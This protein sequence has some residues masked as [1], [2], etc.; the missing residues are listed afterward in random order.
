[1]HIVAIG[2]SDAGISAALRAREVD[3]GAEVTVVVADAYPNFSICGIPYYVSGEVTHW[4]NLAHRTIADLEAAGH[5]AAAGHH[6][7]PHRR[8]PAASCS[9]TGPD[10]AEDLLSLR[11]AGH[12][13]RRR[14]GPA[15][16]RRACDALGPGDGVHLLHS[17]GDTFAAHAHPGGDRARQRGHRRR[18]LHR[19]GDGRRADRPRP[20]RSP[21]SSSSPRCCPPSTRELGALVHAELDR[22][23]VTVLTGTAVERDQPRR[24]A[25]RPAGCRSTRSP[26]TA[27]RSPC[28]PTLVLVVV[29]VR[30]DTE[31]RRQRRGRARRP[32]RDR[33]RP[34]DADQPARTSTRPATASITHHRLLGETYLPL[35]TTA[36]KQG[37]V[38]GENALGGSREFAGSLGTQV[39]KIFDQ[40]AARTGLRDHE[41]AAAGFDPVTVGSEADDHKAYYPGSHRIAMRFT[42]DRATG[43]LLGVQL[44]GHKHAEI[45]KRID[46]AATA[47][48]HGMTVDAGQ[49]PRPVL[50]PAARLPLGRRPGRRPG[51]D[52]PG[53]PPDK[54]THHGEDGNDAT[55]APRTRTS[56]PPRAAA[57]LAAAA[58]A[59]GRR[60]HRV[61]VRRHPARR[62]PRPPRAARCG[63]PAP[64]STFDAPFFTVA[65]AAYQ[66][67]HPGVTVSYA[68][69]GS[70]AG[71]TRFTAGTGEL[72]R[73]RRPRQHAPTWPAPAAAPPSRSRSTSAPSSVAY[74]VMTLNGSLKLTGPVL[75]RI[76]LGQ[77]TRWDDPAITALNPGASLPDAY[78]TVVHR[79][80]GSGTTYIFSNYLSHVSPAWATQV[81]TGR[82]L[83]WPVGYGAD[84]NQ[85]VASTIL[86]IPDSIGYA[87]DSYTTGTAINSAAIANR[88]GNYVTPTPA[89]ITADAAAK[90]GHHRGRLLHRQ[91]A[92][93]RPPTRSAATAGSW[94][95]P[96]SPA[97]PPGRPSS[98][99]SAGSPTPGSPTPPTSA[100]SPCPPAVQQ[101]ATATLSRVTG[102][103]G[104]PLTG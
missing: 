86:R 71:I 64:G 88:D 15:A 60:A 45:A 29:G 59:I 35:G 96:A 54:T 20:A 42:G 9:V 25:A 8:A 40:A 44:F 30:P 72:R 21:R 17:M 47:I 49:R 101:L 39:V 32:R 97:R 81:G 75:A 92:R 3:P 73:H 77:I 67:A 78:I 5:A 2:G 95:P 63:S 53:P 58:L 70:S 11:R 79:A 46:I 80:D 50:H 104:Q 57:A 10:G 19:P 52:P 7:P 36:H 48:F 1:M 51:L 4:R 14:P 12:R 74:N 99:S 61:H 65:F 98:R 18:R 87:E 26:P 89:T 55:P 22:H 28:T 66:Q 16:D 103:G 33:G 38:A 62:R 6:R 34:A 56:T 13:H 82:S 37:R 24:S 93:A 27:R 31:P 90:P 84:G 23:G 91:R 69:V 68:A 43:R 100:T 94:S 41:A 76:F 83:H 102:P 85:G